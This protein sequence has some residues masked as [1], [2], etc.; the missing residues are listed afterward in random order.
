MH[1][2]SNSCFFWRGKLK[3]PKV[4]FRALCTTLI[5]CVFFTVNAFAQDEQTY[6]I[7]PSSEEDQDD[8]SGIPDSIALTE[9]TILLGE[10]VPGIGQPVP[11]AS[12]WSVLRIILTLAV[13]AAAI[14]GLIYLVKRASRGSIKQDPFLK[15]LASTPLGTARSAHIIAVGSRAWLVGCAETGVTLISEID[16]QDVLNEMFF[17]DSRK[18]AEAASGRFMDFKALL[19]KLGVPAEPDTPSPDKIRNRIDRIKGQ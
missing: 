9:Q 7:P 14:Y 18:I 10:E 11:A 17:E 15:V 5:I 3:L 12:V 8:D 6:V 1:N 16:D 13:V 19:R 4:A 2:L